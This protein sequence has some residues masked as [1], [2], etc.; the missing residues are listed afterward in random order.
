MFPERIN[1]L[2]HRM[3]KDERDGSSGRHNRRAGAMPCGKAQ[4]LRRT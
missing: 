1:E 2:S 3:K 4:D